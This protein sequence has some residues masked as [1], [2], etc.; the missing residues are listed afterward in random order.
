M[1]NYLMDELKNEEIGVVTESKT[2]TM[3]KKDGK[4]GIEDVES[5]IYAL[6]PGFQEAL[7][8]IM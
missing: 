1:K 2:I 6:L 8:A 7:E 4:W 5:T 3:K